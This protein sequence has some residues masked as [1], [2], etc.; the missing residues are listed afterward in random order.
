MGGPKNKATGLEYVVRGK[1]E[2]AQH[3]EWRREIQYHY[4]MGLQI[5]NIMSTLYPELLVCLEETNNVRTPDEQIKIVTEN[6]A[7]W[8]GRWVVLARW[9]VD[10][11]GIEKW[12]VDKEVWNRKLKLGAEGWA[13]VDKEWNAQQETGKHSWWKKDADKFRAL[14]FTEKVF[15]RI[16]YSTKTPLRISCTHAII[17]GFV[18][19][20]DIDIERYTH[21]LLEKAYVVAKKL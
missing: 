7:R 20:K 12:T 8:V 6:M 2:E 1:D 9:V 19:G 18:V 3:F 15:K 13:D 5:K 21:D 4:G 11:K 16:F 17:C 10:E 14:G